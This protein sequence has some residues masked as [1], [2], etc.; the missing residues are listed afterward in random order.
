MK[1][2]EKLRNLYPTFED[3]A[4]KRA[5][6]RAKLAG[7]SEPIPDPESGWPNFESMDTAAKAFYIAGNY[8]LLEFLDRP[9][10]A[11]WPPFTINNCDGKGGFDVASV[12]QYAVKNK[13]AI[14]AAINNLERIIKQLGDSDKANVYREMLAYMLTKRK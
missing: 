7:S 5:E 6:M 1:M 10:M 4:A 2:N 14:E 8:G 3:C 13:T 9:E 11:A 12:W